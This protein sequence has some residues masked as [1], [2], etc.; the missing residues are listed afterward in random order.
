MGNDGHCKK[1][2]EQN[3]SL[4]KVP[5]HKMYREYLQMEVSYIKYQIKVAYI[6]YVLYKLYIRLIVCV[7]ALLAD[8]YTVGI[9]NIRKELAFNSYLSK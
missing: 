2:N 8:L 4:S 6:L 9:E 1:H 7:A 5:H 3:G